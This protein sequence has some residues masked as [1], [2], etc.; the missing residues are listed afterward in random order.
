[1]SDLSLYSY[2]NSSSAYRVRIAL[3]LKGVAYRLKSV[4]LLRSGGENWRSEYLRINPQGLVPTLVEDHR[5]LTQSLAIIEYLDEV[6]P[7]PPLLPSPARNRAKVR[8][9]S[10]VIACD[11]H[12]LNSLRVRDYLNTHLNATASQQKDWYCHWIFEGFRAIERMLADSTATGAFCFGDVPTLAD[13]CLVP[14]VYN[15]LRYDC[16]LSTFACIRGI[17]AN[18]MAIEA[19]Q[20]ASPENQPDAE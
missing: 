16:D 12:P 18:C 14:Q 2:Y 7:D 4:H 13:L 20:K 10:Q 6:Y 5:T 11:I 17:Y 3:H 8:A 1:M 9:L 15:A 19:F